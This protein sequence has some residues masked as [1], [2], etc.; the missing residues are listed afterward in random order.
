MKRIGNLFE[1]IVDRDNLLLAYNKAS[2]GKSCRGDRLAFADD[3]ERN[4]QKLHD[5]LIEGSY[6]VG[7]YTRFTI[8][9]PKEREICAATFS[10]RVLHH[11]LMNVCEPYFDKWMIYDTYASRKGKGQM[12]AVRRAQ[13]FARRNRFFLKC[14]VRKYFDSIPHAGLIALLDRKFK[15]PRLLFWFERLI[16]SYEKT[17]GRGL[18]IGNLTSQ[19]FANLYLD[20]VDRLHTPYVRY[21]DDFIFWHDDKDALKRIRDE[22]SESLVCHLGLEL[23]PT[24]INRTTSGMDFLGM[25]V[26]PKEVRLNRTS[27]LRYRRKV[28]WLLRHVGDEV[29]QQERLTSLTAFVA[30]ADSLSWRQSV[31]RQFKEREVCGEQPMATTA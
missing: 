31:L 15:D 1:R 24:L 12:K 22:V 25:R 5:G 10:E 29:M 8:Y 21:M 3:L 2:R 28:S 14:D 23:K 20:V 7:R 6:P 4:I 30:Q 16:R 18:P 13:E 9:D 26:F 11:A 27:R 17:P 19:H